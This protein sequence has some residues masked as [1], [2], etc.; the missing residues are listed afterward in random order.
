MK[1]K[2]ASAS[3][4]HRFGREETAAASAAVKPAKRAKRAAAG[5]PAASGVAALDEI[6]Q[7]W[8]RSDSPGMV[9]GVAQHG[10]TIYRRAFGLA[11][12]EHGVANT[13]ATRM[14]I[15]SS[16]KHFACVAAFVL[17]ED[18]KL[19]VDAPIT[20]YIP[21]LP[22]PRGVPTLRQLMNHTGGLR[23]YVD[24][25]TIAAGLTLQPPGRALEM[26]LLQTDANFAPG[27]GQMYCNGGYHLLSIAIERAAGMPFEQ[28]L[29]ERIFEPLGMSETESIPGDMGVIPRMAT[30]HTAR[31]DKSWRRGIFM[32]EE[33]K[34]EGAIVSTIDDMLKWLAHLR[35][36]RKTVAA[37]TDWA[38]LWAPTTLKNGLVSSY[39]LGLFRHDYR[40]VEVI[41][42]SGAVIGGLCQML[43]VPAHELDII[44]LNNGALVSPDAQAKRI[45]DALLPQAVSGEPPKMAESKP[46]SPLFGTKYVN[47]TGLVIGFE[48]C[49]GKL[50]ISM[51]HSPA[52]ALLRDEG[53]TLRVAFE[54]TVIGPYVLSVDELK[55]KGGEPPKQLLVL[56][57][58][59]PVK[60]TLVP[61]KVPSTQTAGRP[62]VGRY[63][64]EHLDAEATIAFDG[65]QLLVKLAGGFGAVR[66]S[67][68]ATS[69]KVFGLKVLG[70]ST[71]ADYSLVA[72]T[73]DGEIAGFYINSM[74]T[75]HLW[76]K[77]VGSAPRRKKGQQS[78]RVA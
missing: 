62:L 41:Y 29:R 10:K 16:S 65:E 78:G 30:L 9:V 66:M 53:R 38:Q 7:N 55:G 56:E 18:G 25:V 51:S 39:G 31:P 60:F 28:F 1:T 75:R 74:R 52:G 20:R 76:F 3:S 15:G 69:A 35:A 34:G 22:T 23:D 48:D 61:R 44:I 2:K 19:D 68:T 11:S 45:I 63:R 14:R 57:S 64:C 46:Y 42:H 54:D 70:D 12:L 26:Q 73:R 71:S 77:R 13:P 4:N 59:S 24:L 47:A 33:I 36:P 5:Q 21:E 43:T 8:N 37:A 67:A 58:G 72:E 6:F 49:A 27:E 40:G 32:S 50:G 17:A